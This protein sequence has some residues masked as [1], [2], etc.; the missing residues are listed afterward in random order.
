MSQAPVTKR[1]ESSRVHHGDTFI[2]HYEWLRAKDDSEVVEYLNTENAYTEQST[3]SQQALRES[4][5]QEIKERT[6]ETDLSV[7]SRHGDWWYFSRTIEG[8]QYP[9]FCRVPAL[10]DGG[11]VEMFS[12]PQVQAGV[13]LDQEQVILDCNEFARELPFFSLG[14]FS[15]SLD[16][17]LLSF[18]VDDSGDER[19]TQYFLDLETLTLSEETL[20]GIFS[21]AYLTPDAS[22]LIYSLV[23]E[24]WRP[25]EIRAHRIGAGEEDCVL[26]TEHD[27]AMWLSSALSADRTHIVITS[28]SSE[29]SEVRLV[30]LQDMSAEPL[31][32]IGKKHRVQY[33]VEPIRIDGVPYV[34]IMHDA[35]ALNSEIVLA[36]YPTSQPFEQYRQLWLKVMPHRS[37]VRI[38]GFD[39][40][41]THLVVTARE[42]TTVRVFLADLDRLRALLRSQ[43][44]AGV[45]FS[46][47]TGFV[48]EIY[49]TG[50]SHVSI[51]SPVI[52]ISYTSWVTPPRIYDYFPRTQEL[53]LRR[54][55]PVLGDYHAEDYQAY[56]MW[57]PARDG[58]MIPISVIHRADLDLSQQHPVF[59]YGY[60]SYEV[61]IDPYF[62]I[63]RLSLLDRGVIYVV[64]HIR[65]GGEMGRQWYQDGKKLQKKNTFTDFVDVTEFLGQRPWV[66][67]KKIAISGASAG[68]LLIG[69]VLNLAPEKYC[70]AIAGVPFVD[71]LTTILDPDLPLSALEWEEWG[72]PIEDVDVYEYM[73]SYSPYENIRHVKYPPIVAVTSFNDTR[74]LYVEP[75]KWVAQLRESISADSATPLLKIEM[76]GG[77]GGGSGRYT[78]WRDIAWE[79]AFALTY[80]LDQ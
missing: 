43:S 13:P 58:A 22:T 45:V 24:S 18:G 71:A 3:Q 66:D 77:H 15:P 33:G 23:D 59:Q 39:F 16:G 4:I 62:S 56:R 27:N 50:V 21:G 72:N 57:A 41:S 49:T 53:I 7:P 20:P 38:E 29:F 10:V 35:D 25:Y 51:D 8:E 65:G 1:V 37:E 12:P 54:E 19:Y 30:P 74:V 70:A 76:D 9:V 67:Q 34:L 61:S 42:N 78:A 48:E 31:L 79:Y 14:S 64:A 75:A 46:E 69:A 60:G 52:R 80:L 40:S 2:D 6:L 73:K 17:S 63:A 32:V 55:T 11:E 26:F 47:P 68:G 5:F 28:F 36:P 44:N